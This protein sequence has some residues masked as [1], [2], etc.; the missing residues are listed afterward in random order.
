MVDRAK[1][2]GRRFLA[3]TMFMEAYVRFLDLKV[4]D[5]E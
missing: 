5:D 4:L 1:K 3:V 2:F